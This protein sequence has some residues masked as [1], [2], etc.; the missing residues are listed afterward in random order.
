MH[1]SRFGLWLAY[2]DVFATAV[3]EMMM[4]GLSVVASKHGLA[5]EIPVWSASGV[6][7]QVEAIKRLSSETDE[8]LEEQSERISNWAVENVSYEAFQ[9]QLKEVLRAVW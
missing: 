1:A 5:P 8:S 6:R 7:A 9:R 2:H 4:A 3:H